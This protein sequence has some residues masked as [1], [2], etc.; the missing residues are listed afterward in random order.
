MTFIAG[1]VRRSS[2]FASISCCCW[3]EWRSRTQ[4]MPPRCDLINLIPQIT[5]QSPAN[6]RC[7]SQAPRLNALHKPSSLINRES[8]RAE[9]PLSRSL[10]RHLPHAWKERRL[11]RVFHGG[12][13]ALLRLRLLLVH[14]RQRARL[15][16]ELGV[17]QRA[18]GPSQHVDDDDLEVSDENLVVGL[19]GTV[20]GRRELEQL[21]L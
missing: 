8:E 2:N 3:Q 15:G 20:D 7:L 11:W 18:R 12:E 10:P 14:R 6:T 5:V 17:T 21:R 9:S 13:E 16:K 1:C 4:G 19:L